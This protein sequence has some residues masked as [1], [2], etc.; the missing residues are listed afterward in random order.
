PVHSLAQPAPVGRAVEELHAEERGP[1][2]R[3]RLTPV[4]EVVH[5]T[6]LVLPEWLISHQDRGVET[7]T[8][9]P[10]SNAASPPQKCQEC[11]LVCSYVSVPPA[12]RARPGGGAARA[13]QPCPVHVEPGHRAARPLASGPQG[14]ARLPGAVPSAH[15]RAEGAPL[16]GR[17]PADGAAASS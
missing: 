6:E 11:S 2:G 5:R 3:V 1:G 15:G 7:S 14:R 8:L 4:Q 9:R 16:A 13:L 10:G 12:P 17:G